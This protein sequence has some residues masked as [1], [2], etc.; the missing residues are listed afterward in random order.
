VLPFH[1]DEFWI[2]GRRG[3]T[4][5]VLRFLAARGRRFEKGTPP[6]RRGGWHHAPK[7]CFRNTYLNVIGDPEQ[8]VYCEGFCWRS[9]GFGPFQH[10]WFIDRREPNTALETTLSR[11]GAHCYFG[12][13]I[14]WRSVWRTVLSEGAHVS[15]LDYWEKAAWALDQKPKVERE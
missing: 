10:A 9:D 1:P 8:Y 5:K 14:G 7:K 6:A 15:V 2:Y 4:S 13:P 3:L 11:D 12:I